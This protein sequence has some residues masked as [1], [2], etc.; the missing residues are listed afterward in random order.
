MASLKGGGQ[1]QRLA[2]R[3]TASTMRMDLMEIETQTPHWST[4]SFGGLTDTSATEL[5]ALRA[6]LD[7]C[8]G[9]RGPLFALTCA[10]EAVGRFL[11][12]R[13]ITVLVLVTL[14]G[15]FASLMV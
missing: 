7:W 3:E 2:R 15:I 5:A 8:N 9:H 6:H 4:S 12:P 11:A 10:T 14:I 13:Q 1:S